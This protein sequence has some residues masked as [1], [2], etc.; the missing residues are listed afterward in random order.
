MSIFLLP[1]SVCGSE[2]WNAREREGEEK[3]GREVASWVCWAA[4]LLNRTVAGWVVTL[5]PR[6]LVGFVLIL[7]LPLPFELGWS[8]SLVGRWP[9]GCPFLTVDS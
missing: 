6:S 5:A 3:R 7:V 4:A 9:P 2:E 8:S 1:M